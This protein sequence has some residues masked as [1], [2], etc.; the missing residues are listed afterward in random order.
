MEAAA[1][2]GKSKFRGLGLAGLLLA[3]LPSMT[4]G[5]RG[6]T[7]QPSAKVSLNRSYGG[8]VVVGR[9]YVP[10]SDTLTRAW[11]GVGSARLMKC[12]PV[13]KVVGGIPMKS[14]TTLS[15]DST[16]RIALG[17]QFA[18]GQKLQLMLRFQSGRLLVT[19]AVVNR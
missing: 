7:P 14:T 18:A 3:S 16:Y 13:C 1:Q 4:P 12:S 9:I 6:A 15:S 11:S 10:S 5:A 8:A 2:A 17:G 19:Q